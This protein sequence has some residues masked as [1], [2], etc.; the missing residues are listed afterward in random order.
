MCCGFFS[1][2]KFKLHVLSIFHAY[3]H[4]MHGQFYFACFFG[5]DLYSP[6][7]HRITPAS[8]AILEHL[9]LQ[10]FLNKTEHWLSTFSVLQRTL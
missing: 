6:I 3:T 10:F 1:I 8:C 5:N 7:G 4:L 9:R 2:I